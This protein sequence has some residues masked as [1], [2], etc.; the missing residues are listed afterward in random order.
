MII[1]IIIITFRCCLVIRNEWRNAIMASHAI[2]F[3]KGREASGCVEVFAHLAHLAKHA[4]A[5]FRIRWLE[6]YWAH[7]GKAAIVS[8]IN[9]WPCHMFRNDGLNAIIA[10]H[11]IASGKGREAGGIVDL[12]AAVADLVRQP[13][14]TG[15]IR[16]L[17]TCW[18]HIG[19]AAIALAFAL[20]TALAFIMVHEWL[21]AIM[22]SHATVADEGRKAV[23]I[24]D[25]AGAAS[26]R[27]QPNATSRIFWVA[28]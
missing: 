2:A 15:R 28:T 18:A 1:M 27:D 24:V 9:D 10:S 8:V 11:A 5:T 6:T 20:I 17:A 23:G 7:N 4:Q 12:F 3:G 14:A 21:D 25:A 16:W 26:G 19:D 13:Q 22:A